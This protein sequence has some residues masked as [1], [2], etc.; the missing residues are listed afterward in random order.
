MAGDVLT[1][2]GTPGST[3]EMIERLHS[4]ANEPTSEIT[5]GNWSKTT[6][7][8]RDGRRET[9]DLNGRRETWDV[10]PQN[11]NPRTGGWRLEDQETF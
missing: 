8:T 2:F 1:A 11:G 9:G 5:L 4:G 6:R 10:K 3:A 7:E